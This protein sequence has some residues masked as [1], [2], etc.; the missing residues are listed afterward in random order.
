MYNKTV[1]GICS[2]CGGRVL[3]DTVTWCIL[4]PVPTCERC[5]AIMAEGP[6]IPMVP[7]PRPDWRNN[8]GPTCH[9]NLDGSD[10]CGCNACESRRRAK[11]N[12]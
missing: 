9:G 6:V 4:P 12:G 1:V 3:V 2:L 7:A 10:V 11:E 5:G 8:P